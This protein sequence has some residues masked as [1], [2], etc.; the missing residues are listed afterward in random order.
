MDITPEQKGLRRRLKRLHWSFKKRIIPLQEQ[1][2]RFDNTLRMVVRPV[3]RL[4]RRIYLNGYSDREL[5]ILLDAYLKPGMIFFDIGAHFGQ[6]SLMAAKR[7]GENGAVHAFEPAQETF[8]QLVKNIKM[9][10][11]HSV[12]ANRCALYDQQTTLELN[13][14]QTGMGEFNSFGPPLPGTV[15]VKTTESVEAVCLDTYCEQHR[16]SHINLMKIDA[17]GSE[18]HVIRGGERVLST[19]TAP[20][21]VVEFNEQTCL[22]MGYRTLDLREEL[23]AL[24]YR[25]FR[26][27]QESLSLQSEPRRETYDEMV[28]IIATKDPDEFRQTLQ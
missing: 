17:E 18:R 16:I 1:V 26:F 21:L 14:C 28:N 27:D 11:L 13:I 15:K 20:S 25:L 9:N 4:G 19:R 7:V 6:Y 2:I 12:S 3:D 23:E 5:A 8:D 22:A 24:G 10:Q